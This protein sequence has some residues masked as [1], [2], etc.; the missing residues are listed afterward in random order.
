MI[1]NATKSSDNRGK[2]EIFKVLGLFL[3]PLKNMCSKKCEIPLISF[4]SY[5]DPVPTN[6]KTVTLLAFLIG[7]VNNLKLLSSVV[8]LNIIFIF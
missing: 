4:V 5:F 7:I 8:F 1:E 3:V 6:I 2:S